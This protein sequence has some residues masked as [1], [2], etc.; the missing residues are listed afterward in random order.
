MQS[1]HRGLAWPLSYSDK[2]YGAMSAAVGGPSTQLTSHS[3]S[4]VM[5]VR[6]PAGSQ[7]SCTIRAGMKLKPPGPISRAL[8]VAFENSGA[9]DHGVGLI[10]RV[11]VLAHV[12]GL[13]VRIKSWVARVAGSMRRIAISGEPSPSS[14]RILSHFTC[15]SGMKSGWWAAL[16]AAAGSA[17]A[18]IP[19]CPL[20]AKA[21]AMREDA[22]GLR[23]ARPPWKR[24]AEGQRLSPRSHLR[25][26]ALCGAARRRKPSC[27]GKTVIARFIIERRT[28]VASAAI[29]GPSSPSST[30]RPWITRARCASRPHERAARHPAGSAWRSVNA[31]H[32]SPAPAVGSS[33]DA[34]APPPADPRA[35]GA[36]GD[37]RD[38]GK[39]IRARGA[40]DAPPGGPPHRPRRT[41]AMA[42]APSIPKSIGS[43]GLRLRE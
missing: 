43:K 9:Q 7:A 2:A 14:G 29:S 10:R 1:R 5:K 42:R 27:A 39:R 8:A 35:R 41:S 40:L 11:P 28:D 31:R 15:S 38:V 3:L 21:A 13:G 25:N 17:A 4:T 36:S 24:S 30:L 19:I 6:D 16:G 34:C 32:G 18:S 23:H 26:E 33:R 20:Q 37:R 12:D 22:Q